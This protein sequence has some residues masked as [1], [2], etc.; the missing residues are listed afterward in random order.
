[1]TDREEQSQLVGRFCA[2]LTKIVDLGYG[3]D[4]CDPVVTVMFEQLVRDSLPAD[5]IK[6]L[7]FRLPA[8]RI[9]NDT[10]HGLLLKQAT[11]LHRFVERSG[12]PKVEKSTRTPVVFPF[13]TALGFAGG[14]FMIV[15]H[16]AR[17]VP[18]ML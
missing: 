5:E 9:E 13:M 8:T 4:E 17:F 3:E 7:P 14:V 11:Q 16:L 15:F 6:K 18:A 12:E 10:T 2:S 1:M